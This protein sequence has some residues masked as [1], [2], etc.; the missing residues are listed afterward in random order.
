[1]GAPD[2]VCRPFD[3]GASGTVFGSGAGVVLL[4][5]LE[6]AIADEDPIY[7]VIRGVGINNDGSD[8]VGF[9]APSVDAQARAIAIAHAEADIDPASIGYVEAHGTATPLGDPIE[10]AGLVQ[11]FRLGGVEGGQFCALGS[12]KVSSRRHSPCA[13]VSC[14]RSCISVRPIRPSTRLTARSFSTRLRVPGP[15]A[16][17]RVALA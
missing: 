11:A 7:A 13:T 1:M 6:D 9:T 14:R 3:A 16:R 10:F 2:G 12:A 8:K 4:K 15:M 17:H 5:R